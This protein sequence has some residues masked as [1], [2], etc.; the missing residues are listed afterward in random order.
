M[1]WKHNV[2]FADN[3]INATGN[4][5]FVWGGVENNVVKAENDVLEPFTPVFHRVLKIILSR[6]T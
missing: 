4:F 2:A 5:H 6:F 3:K 1:K